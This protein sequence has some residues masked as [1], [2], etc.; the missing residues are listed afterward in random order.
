MAVSGAKPPIYSISNHSLNAGK[1][2][3]SLAILAL[4]GPFFGPMPLAASDPKWTFALTGQTT[5]SDSSR[6]FG[7]SALGVLGAL[8]APLPLSALDKTGS[9]LR[10]S[11]CSNSFGRPDALLEVDEHRRDGL[12]IIGIAVDPG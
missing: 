1:A 5:G 8:S 9:L 7:T 10:M 6:R 11:M 4:E 3:L 12:A 2:T